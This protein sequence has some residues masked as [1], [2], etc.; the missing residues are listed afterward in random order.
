[1]IYQ[2]PLIFGVALA[3]A[4][5]VIWV[6]LRREFTVPY[7]HLES[8]LRLSKAQNAD[9]QAKLDGA[10]PDQAQKK[11]LELET[12]IKSLEDPRVLSDEQL[13]RMEFALK[14]HASGS[15]CVSRDSGSVE[16]A[17]IQAQVRRFFERQGWKVEGFAGLGIAYPPD[18][19]LVMYCRTGSTP[20][21]DE[22]SATL[23]LNTAGVPFQV[24]RSEPNSLAPPLQL[25]FTDLRDAE[26]AVQP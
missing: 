15:I 4:C 1:M 24:R 7:E 25:F 9:Y 5:A 18:C 12:R 10:S 17:K 26:T 19:G 6:V 21:A 13:A 11:I 23:A 20:S 22:L 2:A 16:S 3:L 14:H 8:E